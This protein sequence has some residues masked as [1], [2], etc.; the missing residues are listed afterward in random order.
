MDL[1]TSNVTPA[2]LAA[3]CPAILARLAESPYTL[4]AVRGSPEAEPAAVITSATVMKTLA[5]NHEAYSKLLAS[6]EFGGLQGEVQR[7]RGVIKTLVAQL[8]TLLGKGGK[9][10]G[11]LAV[12]E[13]LSGREATA[14]NVAEVDRDWTVVEDEKK[15]G[16]GRIE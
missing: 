16:V 12:L 9:V 3:A 4:V 15:L 7:L 13:A 8:E 1:A 5:A 11:G 2:R 14:A 10:E 6:P